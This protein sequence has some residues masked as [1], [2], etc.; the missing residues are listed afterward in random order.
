MG[1][2]KNAALAAEVERVKARH[3]VAIVFDCHSIRST[4]PFLFPGLL[5]VFSIGTNDGQTCAPQ[6]S[7]A[8]SVPCFA[9]KAFDAESLQCRPGGVLVPVRDYNTLHQDLYGDVW[10][11]LQAVII[12]SEPDVDHTGGELVLTEQTPRAQS[13][14]IVLRPKKGDVVIFATNFRPAP[15][16]KGFMRLTFRHGVSE[17]LSGQR[18]A[19]G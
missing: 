14:A 18:H 11:P 9:S 6:V 13:R 19:I 2:A 4:I 3:G 5:P 8:V 7:Q 17:V 10:F 1:L 16:T 15:S 12:A